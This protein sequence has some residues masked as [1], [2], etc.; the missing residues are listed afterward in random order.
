M[1]GILDFDDYSYSAYNKL[2]LIKAP[3]NSSKAIDDLE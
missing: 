2:V 1:R 3:L